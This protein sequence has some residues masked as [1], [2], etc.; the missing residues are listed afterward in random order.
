MVHH[1][2]RKNLLMPTVLS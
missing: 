2:R 1:D